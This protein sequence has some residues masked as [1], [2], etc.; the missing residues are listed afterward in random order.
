MQA[1]LAGCTRGFACERTP[2]NLN[3]HAEYLLMQAKLAGCT[4]GFAYEHTLVNSYIK[5]YACTYLCRPSWQ[6]A[7]AASNLYINAC[8][9]TY[10]LMQAKLAGCTHGSARRLDLGQAKVSCTVLCCS[11]F[12]IFKLYTDYFVVVHL[13]CSSY[14]IRNL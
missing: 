13:L 6:A 3:I 8:V 5:A 7:R 2:I 11:S 4:C 9:R 1:K 10:L 12:A 14:Y